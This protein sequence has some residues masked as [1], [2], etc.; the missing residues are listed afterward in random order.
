MQISRKLPVSDASIWVCI[1]AVTTNPKSLGMATSA[2]PNCIHFIQNISF[3]PP[4][5]PGPESTSNHIQHT[6]IMNLESIETGYLESNRKRCAAW[7]TDN[8]RL[9]QTAPNSSAGSSATPTASSTICQKSVPTISS[10]SKR[11][12]L[13]WR[14]WK[15]HYLW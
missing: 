11:S 12:Q 2:L 15:L 10:P 8:D 3:F 13:T 14:R 1:L 4:Q 6:S 7:S 5:S 9:N